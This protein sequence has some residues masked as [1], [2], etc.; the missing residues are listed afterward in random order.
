[1]AEHRNDPKRLAL[2]VVLC[3]GLCAGLAFLL[4]Q[5]SP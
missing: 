3:L 2:A 5:F 4:N 1:M